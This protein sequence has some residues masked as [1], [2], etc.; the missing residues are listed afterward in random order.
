MT[1]EQKAALRD[2]G[3]ND[4]YKFAEKTVDD[5]QF[6]Y[7]KGARPNWARGAVGATLFTF[8][9][10][11]VSM[12]EVI[13]KASPKAKALIGAALILVAGIKG[14]PF[15]EDAE[16]IIDTIGQ[17][18]GYRTNSG[19]EIELAA[20]KLLGQTLGGLLLHGVTGTG[21]APFDV[22]QRMGMANIIPVPASSRL[23]EGRERQDEGGRRSLWRVWRACHPG[24]A[25]DR[26]H[27]VARHWGRSGR[28]CADSNR[29]RYQSCR[30]GRQGHVSRQQG[31][32]SGRHH[33]NGRRRQGVWRQ[34]AKVAKSSGRSAWWPTMPR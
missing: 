17:A 25:H 20:Y 16:D 19:K 13:G 5:T 27:P 12:L 11:T 18:L 26:R 10:F 24:D 2:E 6:V 3:V 22:S 29:Q 7:N 31:Q 14:L 34:P 4:A 9:T 30:Y 23:V 28:G 15:E 1:P 8:K 32:K 21:A 33:A